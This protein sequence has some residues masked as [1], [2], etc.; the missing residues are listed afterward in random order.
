MIARKN[1]VVGQFGVCG[2]FLGRATRLHVASRLAQY[3]SGPWPIF[4]A[5]D[6]QAGAGAFEENAERGGPSV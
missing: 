2:D 4:R 3:L 5:V 6:H 1:R